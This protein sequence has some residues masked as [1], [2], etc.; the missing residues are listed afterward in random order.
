MAKKQLK[1]GF[2]KLKTKE[3]VLLEDDD[4]IVIAQTQ[5]IIK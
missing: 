2:K 3:G 4:P 5:F 1:K